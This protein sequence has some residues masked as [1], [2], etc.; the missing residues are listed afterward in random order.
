M[1]L[2]SLIAYGP[3][4]LALLMLPETRGRVAA[5]ITPDDMTSLASSPVPR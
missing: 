1:L 2:F 4:L 5:D 3:M